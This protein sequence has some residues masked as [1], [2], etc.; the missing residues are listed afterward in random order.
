MN[1]PDK[2]LQALAACVDKAATDPDIHVEYATALITAKKNDDALKQLQLASAE[3]DA[4]PSPPSMFG[5]N[6]DDA[7]H[8]RI[9]SAYDQLK[10]TDLGDAERKKVKPPSQQPGGG[11]GGMGGFNIK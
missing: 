4:K 3:I 11:M 2:Q 5:G 10:R 1:L 9:A 8:E 6:P 7:R